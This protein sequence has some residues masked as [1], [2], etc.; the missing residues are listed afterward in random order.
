MK[1]LFPLALALACAPL[2]SG[3]S[4]NRVAANAAGGMIGSGMPAF[5]SDPDTQT[6]RE[7][8]LAVV[9]T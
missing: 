1:K 7:S 2:L 3:C 5:L 4:L 8:M 9:K 6:A